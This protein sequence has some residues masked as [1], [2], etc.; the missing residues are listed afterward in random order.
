MAHHLLGNGHVMVD[1]TVVYLELETNEVRQ[2]G[3]R[4][5]LGPNRRNLLAWLGPYDRE[6]GGTGIS[7]G[8]GAHFDKRRTAFFERT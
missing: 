7:A 5:G 6:S 8:V 2:D 4:T 1:L 3:C